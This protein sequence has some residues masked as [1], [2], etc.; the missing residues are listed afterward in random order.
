MNLRVRDRARAVA[1]AC[2]RTLG[3]VKALAAAKTA[4]IRARTR[5]AVSAVFRFRPSDRAWTFLVATVTVALGAFLVIAPARELATGRAFSLQSLLTLC[6]LATGSS[7][8]AAG[9]GIFLRMASFRRFLK[10]AFVCSLSLPIAFIYRTMALAVR[11]RTASPEARGDLETWIS[12]GVQL[13]L[14]FLAVSGFLLFLLRFKRLRSLQCSGAAMAS[15]AGPVIVGGAG[16]AVGTAAGYL[17]WLLCRWLGFSQGLDFFGATV[18]AVRVDY[19]VIIGALLGASLFVFLTLRRRS[20][21]RGPSAPRSAPPSPPPSA[22]PSASP[23]V[24]SPASSP[25]SS[26]PSSAPMTPSHFP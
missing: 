1:A 13:S 2:G 23:S 25:A 10:I 19:F 7:M 22:S 20:K 26:A 3:P 21:R 18:R 11:M 16:A 6:W 12:G 24:S 8:L 9:V 4:G 15:R 14:F 17:I 5:R